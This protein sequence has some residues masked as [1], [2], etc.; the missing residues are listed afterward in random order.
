[1]AANGGQRVKLYAP[2]TWAGGSSYAHLDYSTFSGTTNRLMVYAISS[3]VA[4]HD[5]GSVTMGLLRD[6]GWGG[7]AATSHTLTVNSSGATGVAIS[8]SPATYA[9]TTNYSKTGIA[10]GTALTLTAPSSAGGATFANW[11]GCTTASGVTCYVTV[12]ASTSVTANYSAPSTY[13]LSVNSSGASGVAIS[14]SP[15]TYTGTSPYSKTG[16]ATGTVILL[17]APATSANITF[18]SW[19]GCDS[20][21]GTSCTVT[22]SA[23]RSVTATYSGLLSQTI[24]F[25]TPP[26]VVVGGT[27]TVSATGGASGQQVIFSSITPSS[28]TVSGNT[29]TGVAVGACTIAANQAGN[30]NYGAAPQATQS[31]VVTVPVAYGLTVSTL[32]A[33]GVAIVASPASY[34]GT[35]PYSKTSISAGTSIALV[36]P[37]TAGGGTF[38]GWSGCDSS[39]TSSTCTVA[40]TAAKNVT[41]SYGSS[42]ASGNLLLNPGFESG[43]TVWAQASTGGRSLISSSTSNSSHAGSYYAWL[44]NAN[45]VTD[46][47]DQSVTIPAN[48]WSASVD[49]WYRITTNDGTS[50]VYDTLEVALYS[51]TGTK[52]ATLQTLSNRSATASWL[53]SSSVDV[54]AYIGQTVRLRFTARSDSSGTTDFFVDDVNLTAIIS[55]S[56]VSQTITFGAAPSVIAG[57]TGTVSVAASSGLPVSLTST[58]AGICSVSGNTV[59]GLAAGTCTIAANQ[60]G[61]SNYSAAPQVTQNVTVSSAPFGMDNL[62]QNPGF[63][64]GDAFWTQTSSGGYALI[65]PGGGIPAHSGSYYAL[66]GGYDL[67]IDTLEQSVTIPANVISANLE[68]WYKI[69]T[70]ETSCYG[71]DVLAVE[72]YRSSSSYPSE[73]KTLSNN[74]ATG[75]GWVKSSALDLSAYQGQTVRLRFSVSTNSTKNTSFLIDDLR[76]SATVLVGQTIVFGD[77]PSVFEG[78]TGTVSATASSGLPVLLNSTTSRTCTLTGNT[79][80]GV[81]GG[82]CTITANQAGDSGYSAAPQVTQSFVITPFSAIVQPSPPT[83]ISITPGRGSATL[84]LSPPSANGGAPIVAYGASCS[85]ASQTTKTAAGAGLTLAVRGLKGGVEYACTATAS[86]AFY[87]S[88]ASAPVSVVPNTGGGGIAPILLLLLD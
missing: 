38:T 86:N 81:S 12:N 44:G 70:Q 60:A 57:S 34:G 4:I 45:S 42:G 84:N 11:S 7:A 72:L 27:G 53:K 14:A 52:L 73:L 65:A 13:T 74:D 32:G 37:A 3:G 76:L 54:S 83:V 41:A 80:T 16:I 46:T 64:S 15:A 62:I 23:T 69:S 58:T 35:T 85:A 19:S 9:G 8:A 49:F 17:T 50:T 88:S 48:A 59:S 1:M 18:N 66:L 56:P 36:A 75:G 71:C 28:C 67:A 51:A 5:P 68:F 33:T 87:A 47:L 40:M 22:M 6:L 24:A 79:V 78:G 26:S 29:V 20:S 61:N 55:G 10:G 21:S 25:G 82:T 63:E 43:A 31:I 30:A 2:S 77:A 39:T